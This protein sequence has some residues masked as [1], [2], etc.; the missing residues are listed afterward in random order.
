MYEEPTDVASS[1]TFSTALCTPAREAALGLAVRRHARDYSRASDRRAGSGPAARRARVVSSA[2]PSIPSLTSSR[3]RRML[4]SDDCRFPSPRREPMTPTSRRTNDQAGVSPARGGAA[5]SGRDTPPRRRRK[6]AETHAENPQHTALSSVASPAAAGDPLVHARRPGAAQ[7]RASRHPLRLAAGDGR[8]H[9]HRSGQDR[10]RRR[11]SRGARAT[12]RTVSLTLVGQTTDYILPPHN[13]TPSYSP[14]LTASNR[15]YF[16]GAGGTRLLPRRRRR[17]RTGGDRP[18]GLLRPGE[19]HGRAEHAS[20]RRS[21]STRRSPPTAPARSTSGFAPAA[22]RRSGCRAASRASMRT[23]TA[24]GSR[25]RPHPGGDA[26]ITRVPHQVR[27][28]A[29]AT[30]GTPSTWSWR[31]PAPPRI[32]YLVGL[33]SVDAGARRSRRPG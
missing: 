2:A 32:R 7:R 15:V 29:A 8:Q 13:W 10:Q 16:A 33:D 31:A 26:S 22:A 14:T 9:R 1:P 30:T 18:T 27:T 23:A 17:R 3:C 25:R 4:P 28:G 24:V 19:L 6:P 20:T 11:L 21:S 12:A 5:R